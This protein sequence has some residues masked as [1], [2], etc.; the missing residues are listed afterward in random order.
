M[1]KVILLI[2]ATAAATLALAA[3]APAAASSGYQLQISTA[4]GQT[5]TGFFTGRI[6]YSDAVVLLQ[7]LRAAAIAYVQHDYQGAIDALNQFKA[8]VAQF[9]ADGSLDP[10]LGAYLTAAADRA[11]AYL[12][13]LIT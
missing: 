4:C 11:I 12:E 10:T 7:D 5:I 3:P 9:V 2:T 1:F 6:T 13:T 8:D